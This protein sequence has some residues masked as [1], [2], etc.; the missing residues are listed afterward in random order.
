MGVVSVIPVP[1]FQQEYHIQDQIDCTPV[2]CAMR[3]SD[4]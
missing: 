3:F 2:L 4:P 1:H